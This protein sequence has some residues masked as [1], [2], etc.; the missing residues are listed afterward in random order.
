MNDRKLALKCSYYI[1]ENL[2][3]IDTIVYWYLK[4]GRKNFMGHIIEFFPE[5]N[6]WADY[7]KNSPARYDVRNYWSGPS[8]RVERL[9][10]SLPWGQYRALCGRPE[11]AAE[12]LFNF[13]LDLDKC[14]TLD[15]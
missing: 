9:G 11:L 15:S 8:V 2:E 6:G 5:F 4:D 1:Y 10:L 7:N 13:A 14:A 12:R 3:F